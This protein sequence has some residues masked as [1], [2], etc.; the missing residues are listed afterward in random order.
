MEILLEGVPEMGGARWQ[1]ARDPIGQAQLV[2]NVGCKNRHRLEYFF[3][4]KNMQQNQ[5]SSGRWHRSSSQ[6]HFP[7]QQARL[8]CF[9]TSCFTCVVCMV[10]TSCT[11]SKLFYFFLVPVESTILPLLHPFLLISATCNSQETNCFCNQ[12]GADWN[13]GMGRCLG[14]HE[15]GTKSLLLL[16]WCVTTQRVYRL[17]YDVKFLLIS[18]CFSFFLWDMFAHNNEYKAKNDCKATTARPPSVNK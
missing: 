3:F 7:L 8:I 16:G 12:R 1:K 11:Y 18:V 5:S 9:T 4:Y 2:W 17:N 15:Q 10:V 13:T 6:L 14:A